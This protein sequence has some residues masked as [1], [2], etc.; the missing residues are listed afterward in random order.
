MKLFRKF[1]VLLILPF[2]SL[3]LVSGC[4]SKPSNTEVEKAIESELQSRFIPGSWIGS[5]LSAKDI[6]LETVKIKEWGSYNDEKKYWPI[7]VRVIGDAELQNPYGQGRIKK[8]D[9]VAEFR[10]SKDDYGKWKATLI[11]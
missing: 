6:K 11:L 9:K 7:K 3:S 5:M 1:F 10:L 8:I 4:S 2:I